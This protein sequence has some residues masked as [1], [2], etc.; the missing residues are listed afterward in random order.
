MNDQKYI[1]TQNCPELDYDHS[2]HCIEK[3]DGYCNQS[4]WDHGCCPVGNV[5]KWEPYEEVK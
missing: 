4:V 1:C 5:P 3:E 2:R